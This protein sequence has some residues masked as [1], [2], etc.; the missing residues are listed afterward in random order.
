[1]TFC[2]EV[3]YNK[4]MP[5]VPK[6]KL[7]PISLSKETIGQ[8]IA[9][10]RKLKGWTQVQL[11]RNIGIERTVIANYE[12]DRLRIYDEMIGRI[13]LVL[14]VS[15]DV[16]LGISEEHADIPKLSLRLMRRLSIVDSFPEAKK[17][18]ILQTLDDSIEANKQKENSV[19][20][21]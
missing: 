17:K 18:R 13:S 1:M 14:G 8:R 5:R 9:R 2:Q 11:A 10:F 20:T 16:L 15:S 6:Q 3:L 21:L 12:K 7:L 4:N 19:E